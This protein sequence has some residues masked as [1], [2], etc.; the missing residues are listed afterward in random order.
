[1][2]NIL[3]RILSHGFAIAVVAL[4]A[5]GLIYRGELFP[6][7]QLPSFLVPDSGTVADA[8]DSA[9]TA[10][11]DTT[12][13]QE[14]AAEPPGDGGPA[15]ATVESVPESGIEDASPET[16]SADVAA[17]VEAEPVTE[18]AVATVTDV[19]GISV[20]TAAPV[21][22]ESVPPPLEEDAVTI[23][24]AT[25]GDIAAVPA[26]TEIVTPPDGE[27]T[28]PGAGATEDV[29]EAVPAVETDTPLTAALESGE[30]PATDR[31]VV[32]PDS[33]VEATV[34]VVEP[35][36]LVRE[37]EIPATESVDV[38]RQPAMG[39][40]PV[41][42]APTAETVPAAESRAA[43]AD[44]A[45]MEPD[46]STDLA[47]YQLLAAARESFWKNDYE[48]AEASYRSLIDLDPGNPDGYG[49]LG[50]FYFSQGKWEEAA[51]AF[52][53]AG[54]RLVATGHNQLASGLV[55][56]IRGLNGSQADELETLISDSTK[57]A[58]QP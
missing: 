18:E 7:M 25:Q 10:G 54:K 5:I 42:S 13:V 31:P 33:S 50:N 56:V 24:E 32:D 52:F 48:A 16:T 58:V 55:N 43:F 49:E 22:A 40:E 51:T 1:M 57:S 20:E 11:R 9:G 35:V 39:S 44:E 45:E 28:V 14:P 46:K 30:E 17:P 21:A 8:D 3:A 6:D 47:S 34:P 15:E 26:V 2:I 23:E 19:E 41:E 37:M 4:L 12:P 36:P 29:V 53:E 38:A 27:E